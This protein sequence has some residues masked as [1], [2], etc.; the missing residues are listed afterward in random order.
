MHA[1]TLLRFGFDSVSV[2]ASGTE[3]VAMLANYP[4]KNTPQYFSQEIL[5][6]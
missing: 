3:A 2:F 1:Q 6:P 5:M 4:W